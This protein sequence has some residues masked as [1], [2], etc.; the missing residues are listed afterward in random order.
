[1]V[2][3]DVMGGTGEAGTGCIFTDP[4]TVSDGT[5]TITGFG[6]DSG[7]CHSISKVRLI[8]GSDVATALE[9]R[10]CEGS[11]VEMSCAQGTINILD[12]TYGRRHGAEVCSHNAVSNQDCHADESVSI[13]MDACQGNTGCIVE[14]TNGVFGDP[15]GGTYKYL[16]V[17]YECTT[18]GRKLG[19]DGQLVKG[20]Q[21][22]DVNI[23]LDY[24]IGLAITPGPNIVVEWSSIVHFTATDTNCCDYGSRI[25]GVWF[26][27]NS[28]KIL[29]VDGHGAD[30]NSHTGQWGC[31]DDVLTYNEGTRY[32]LK[33]V[34]QAKTVQISSST[35]GMAISHWHASRHGQIVRSGREP[36]CT[37]RT[38]GTIRPMPLSLAST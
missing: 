11:S 17:N 7:K 2:C 31:D 1:M 33:M 18:T 20:V 10:G 13:V 32:T 27:P 35:A 21:L 3:H 36:S 14:A 25:P 5:F 26:W 15:C 29:V 8:G 28:R 19:G 4:V 9:V 22:E 12:A 37:W 23:P 24:E 16:T 30:G 34:M 6:H 38:R